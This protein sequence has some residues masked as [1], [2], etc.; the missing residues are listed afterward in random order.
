M[1]PHLEATNAKRVLNEE[2]KKKRREAIKLKREA[3]EKKKEEQRLEE[4]KARKEERRLKREA[5]IKRREA[6][7]KKGQEAKASNASS[8][9]PDNNKSAVV[10]FNYSSMS[11]TNHDRKSF[12]NMPADKL[13][14]FDGTNFIKWK[15]LMR[16]YVIGLHLD[17]WEVVFNGFEPLVDP[18]N[19]TM[20]E[21]RIIHLNGQAT[22]V[23]LSALD[24]DEYNRV[25]G[26]DVAK[27]IWDTLHMKGLTK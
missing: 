13:H 26:V 8:S 20:E 4:K 6:R 15:H 17:I 10:S 11:M 5:R 1:L 19:P 3:R 24:G 22:S 18:K 2:K 23:I 21:M 27:Q 9:E 25:I 12:I 16:A 7:N 14:H